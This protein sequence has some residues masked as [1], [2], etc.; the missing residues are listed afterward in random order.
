MSGYCSLKPHVLILT[1]ETTGE[2]KQ[3]HL[4]GGN[5]DLETIASDYLQRLNFDL[6]DIKANMPTAGK[7]GRYYYCTDT[8]EVFRDDG[9]TWNLIN[10]TNT[11]CLQG[12]IA[13][14]PAAGIKGRRFYATDEDLVY[15]DDSTDWNLINDTKV[16]RLQ[17][18]FADR[19]VAGIQGRRFL[20]TDANS[21]Y[22][23]D[24]ST[25]QSAGNAM[26]DNRVS[27][28]MSDDQT[29]AANT[30]N[31]LRFDTARY[32]PKSL[33]DSTNYK[34][35]VPDP[36]LYLVNVFVSDISNTDTRYKHLYLYKNGSRIFHVR[37]FMAYIGT[38]DI[39]AILNLAANDYLE[40]YIFNDSG[41]NTLTI[42]GGSSLTRFE[43]I[44]LHS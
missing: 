40:T 6:Q 32:D 42:Y 23:D 16:Y 44:G 31:K 21:L 41:D 26:M 4:T 43:L 14:R 7:Q 29:I 18:L 9:S 35:T 28:Y 10:A 12:L 8:D 3:I 39:T 22:I 1:D 2:L 37:N 36:G 17:G 33:F 11:Y 27:T 19:P 20:A 15:I 38:Q 5:L 13:D 24:G 25:W 34:I 30:T